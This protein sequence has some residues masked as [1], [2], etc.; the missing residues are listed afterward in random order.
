LSVSTTALYH[1]NVD[2]ARFS[3]SFT[4]SSRLL[5]EVQMYVLFLERWENSF[6]LT[7]TWAGVK[8]KISKSRE[9]WGE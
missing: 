3:D 6:L 8:K 1:K 9:A 4:A 7:D 5:Q 2:G